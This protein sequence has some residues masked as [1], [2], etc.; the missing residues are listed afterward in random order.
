MRLYASLTAIWSL[1]SSIQCAE[2]SGHGH[3]FLLD[4]DVSIS[5]AHHDTVDPPSARLIF[6][7]RLDLSEFYEIGDEDEEAI[8]RINTFGGSRQPLLDRDSQA[9]SPS[10]VFILVDGVEKPLDLVPS[11]RHLSFF[12]IHPAPNPAQSQQLV[13]EILSYDGRYLS[14]AVINA[15]VERA[16][17]AINDLKGMNMHSRGPYRTIVHVRSLAD[18]RAAHGAKSMEY[19]E[20][21]DLLRTAFQQLAQLVDEEPVVVTVVLLP[22]EQHCSKE[23]A[24]LYS[25]KR[26]E[27][28][29]AKAPRQQ[30][31]AP[32]ELTPND[33]LPLPQS[34]S[35]FS[36]LQA[37]STLPLGPVPT[38]FSSQSACESGTNNCTGHGVCSLK[39]TTKEGDNINNCYGCVCSIP[40]IRTNPDGSKKTTWYGG[41]ACQKKDVVAPFW[42]LAGTTIFFVSIISFGV[43]LLYSMGNEE[44]PSVIGAGV[45]GPR[46]K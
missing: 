46:A 42:L 38:C 8:Q 6:A 28:R 34:A 25:V 44:L 15:P 17:K 7:E 45:S 36:T 11:S 29:S 32:L 35:G 24:N 23:S 40:D 3:V 27:P 20:Q 37:T 13:S 1:A 30:P 22:L 33:T 43:G 4:R 41:G 26:P 16:L 2:A 31:E 19:R 39:F 14:P 18:M 9:R 21:L 5:A 12:D 10:R